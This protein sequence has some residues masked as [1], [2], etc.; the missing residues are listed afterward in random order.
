M[1]AYQTPTF[2]CNGVRHKVLRRVGIVSNIDESLD[3]ALLD[4]QQQPANVQNDT[5]YFDVV[6]YNQVV[7]G[8]FVKHDVTDLFNAV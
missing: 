3:Q 1:K 6:V 5:A 8:F 2:P 4:Y 7:P